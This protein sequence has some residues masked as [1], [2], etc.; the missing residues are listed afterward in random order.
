MPTP[1]PP[2]PDSPSSLCTTGVESAS[3]G[4]PTE[5]PRPPS[6]ATKP[7][8]PAESQLETQTSEEQSDT[9]EGETGEPDGGNGNGI[10]TR[11][12]RLRLAVFPPLAVAALHLIEHI[13]DQRVLVILWALIVLLAVETGLILNGIFFRANAAFHQWSQDRAT[14]QPRDQDHPEAEAGQQEDDSDNEPGQRP[15]SSCRP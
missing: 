3:T 9:S 1:T 12:R 15:S 7:T 14:A 8:P 11:R 6:P 10:A 2:P 13:H 4:Q 5:Q